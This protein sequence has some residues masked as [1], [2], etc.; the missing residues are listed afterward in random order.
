MDSEVLVALSLSMVGG[1]STSLGLSLTHSLNPNPNF[2]ISF[3]SV[4]T[5]NILLF[6][7]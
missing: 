1:L 2:S 5:T 6:Y 7:D 4:F 3:V